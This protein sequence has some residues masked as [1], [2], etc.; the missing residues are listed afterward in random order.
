METS[1]RRRLKPVLTSCEQRRHLTTA[2][3]SPLGGEGAPPLEAFTFPPTECRDRHFWATV[4]VGD[5][6]V[7]EVVSRCGDSSAAVVNARLIRTDDRLLYDLKVNA[8]VDDRTAG[9][10]GLDP[11]DVVVVAV[12]DVSPDK[13]LKCQFVAK[14]DFNYQS[15]NRFSNISFNNYTSSSK[16]ISFVVKKSVKSA[17]KLSPKIPGFEKQRD[18][19][20]GRKDYKLSDKMR[21]QLKRDEEIERRIQEM[22]SKT[23][24]KLN[25]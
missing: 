13:R 1:I 24:H 19:G 10:T 12:T 23:V 6:V 3:V 2:R 5:R 16:K 8:L 25:K 4:R 15:L 18:R 7:A 17:P 9:P 21:K 11:K 14:T 20:D 22:A